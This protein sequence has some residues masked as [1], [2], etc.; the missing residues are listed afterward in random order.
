MAP[1]RHHVRSTGWHVTYAAT[2]C[3]RTGITR[4]TASLMDYFDPL[5][6]PRSGRD[7]VPGLVMPGLPVDEEPLAPDVLP[8]EPELES[9]GEV[10][11]PE[12]LG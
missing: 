7:S 9:L 6:P 2:R 3:H 11:L 12:L 1:A 4:H 10:L 8:D 5:S